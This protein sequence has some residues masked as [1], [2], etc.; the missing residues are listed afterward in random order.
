MRR[1]PTGRM[2]R[3]A[4]FAAL[5]LWPW[6]PLPTSLLGNANTAGL[7][8]LPA[9]S[10]VLL[11][12][13]VGQVSLAQASFVGIGAYITA[14]ATRS[15]G[16][17]FPLNVPVGALSAALAAALL[18]L[19][20]LRVRGLY[21]AVATLI[22]A[23]AADAYLFTSSWMGAMGG[24]TSANVKPIGRPDGIPYVDFSD[25]RTFY[26]LVLAACGL[27]VFA[28]LNLRDSKVGRAFN[29][30]RGSE[31]AAASFG[32][33]VVRTKLVAFAVAG[34]LAGLAGSMLIVNQG[35]VVSEQ[36]DL[37]KSLFYLS[38]AV[39]GGLSSIGGAV[40]AAV[41][42]AALDELF[43]RVEAFAGYLDVTSAL[44]LAGVLLAYPG[45]LAAGAQSLA[46]RVRRRFAPVE[47]QSESRRES[48]S[49]LA[50]SDAEIRSSEPAEP[51]LGPVAALDEPILVASG[52]TVRFG[53]LTAVDDVSLEVRPGQI[54]GLIGPNGAG[55]TTLFNA[56]SGLNRPTAGTVR[57]AG[58]DATS[59]A[60]HQRAALGLARTFQV[61]QLF[62]QLDVV[63]NVLVGTHLQSGSNELAH[64]ALTRGAIEGELAAVR[65]AEEVIDLLGLR[66]VARRP[67]EG[68]PFGML[69]MVELARAL[70]TGAP[71]VMLDEPASGLD[72]AETDR[73]SDVLRDIRS[74]FGTSFLV[75]EHDVRMVTAL[76]DYLYVVDR[77]RL[78]AQG[79]PA[80]VQR[81]PAVVAAYL[82]AP[83]QPVEIS[84]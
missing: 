33:D 72:N 64:L 75:I 69:R 11:T 60:V 5:V 62:P 44:L 58:S 14:L 66:D 46:D 12:G 28:V 51:T 15:W 38:I 76:C 54:V 3:L 42:F 55:K 8:F 36:F 9:V 43:F 18:G 31:V 57:I 21:L 83:D 82:G 22:F 20:A 13:W 19:V 52:I 47:P 45:G 53:G 59:L 16:L 56:V 81:D 50:G 77:G 1:F 71:L 17:G 4:V 35:A 27:A 34:F 37:A 23:W 49:D 24:S 48:P 10:L 6:L 39:V 32:V 79:A 61:L 70:A 29:A 41:L 67:V 80:D 84:A 74:R 63:G 30:V 40:A 78:I 26:Y 25:R 68:L 73:L 7:Y 65:R 2:A